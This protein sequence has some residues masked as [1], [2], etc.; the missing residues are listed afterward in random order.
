MANLRSELKT[1]VLNFSVNQSFNDLALS[2]FQYQYH[3]NKLYRKFVEYLSV[4]PDQI[5]HYSKIPFLPIG[6]FKTQKILSGSYKED[7]IFESS[8]TGNETRSKHYVTDV[9]FYNKNSVKIFESV[10]GNLQEKVIL[11]MLPSYLERGNSSLVHMVNYFMQQTKNSDSTFYLNDFRTLAQKLEILKKQNKEVVLFGVTFALIDFCKTFKIDFPD[12]K[13]IETGGMKG[14]GK[15]LIR[16]EL[17]QVI[18]VGFGVRNVYSEYGMT[19]LLSQAYSINENGFG[20]PPQMKVLIR[21]LYDPRAHSENG[22][23]AISIID[24]A[25]IDSCSFIA[26]DDKG[27]IKSNGCF[28]ILGRMDTSEIRGCSLLTV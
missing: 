23:G 3:H 12:L 21:D 20:M 4:F 14:R 11:G 7:Q 17:H 24:L 1:K 15:E 5:Q 18:K 28:D 19:E 2:V 27:E 6:F 13:I 16:A 22:K 10:F 25:N 26:T 9:D 8:G